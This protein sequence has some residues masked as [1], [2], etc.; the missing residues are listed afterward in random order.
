MC[1]VTGAA[2]IEVIRLHLKIYQFGY[3]YRY[4]VAMHEGYNY[5][6]VSHRFLGVSG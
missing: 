2:S 6:H 1:L 5:V 3:I 4:G